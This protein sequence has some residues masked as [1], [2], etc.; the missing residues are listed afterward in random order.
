MLTSIYSA[1]CVSNVVLDMLHT[2]ISVKID[3]IYANLILE[4]IL[5]LII[6][7][8]FSDFKI[9]ILMCNMY[10]VLCKDGELSLP[11]YFM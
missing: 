1:V 2:S 7:K 11:I 4:T 5:T 10:Y 6:T 3:K 8:Y 9:I